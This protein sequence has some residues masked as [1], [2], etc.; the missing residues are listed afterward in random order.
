VSTAMIA[1]YYSLGAQMDDSMNV[2]GFNNE[3]ALLNM[4]DLADEQ[5][6]YSMNALK[7]NGED[8]SMFAVLYEGG[9]VGREGDASAKL[10]ALNE[11]WRAFIES[12]AIAYLMRLEQK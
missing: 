12:R 8:I 10:G 9:R 6:R 11:Y 3:K 2:T 5:A 1:K 4:L 7:D